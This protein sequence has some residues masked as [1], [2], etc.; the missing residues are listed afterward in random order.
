MLIEIRD[1]ASSWVAYIIIGLLVLSFALWGIQEYFGGGATVPVAEINGNEISQV[2]FNNQFQQYKQR[3][4]AILGNNYQQQYPD[5]G[6]I[7]KDVINSMVRTELLRQEVT[8]AGYRISDASLIKNIQQ[9]PQF[10]QDGKFDPALYERSLSAGRYNKAQFERE[11]REQEQ[12]RQMEASLAASSFIPKADLQRF[13]KLSEQTRDF[14]YAIVKVSSDTISVSDEES[15]NY[16]NENQQL[17]QTPEQ[18]KLAYVELKE[19]D[20][21]KEITVNAEDVRAIYDGQPERYMTD[22]LRKTRHILLK[23][24]NEAGADGL[25]W[26]E[27]LDKA[28][29]LVKQLDDGGDFAELATQHSQDSLSA[30]KGGEIGLIAAGD[31]TNKELEDTLF[32]L[33]VGEYSRPVRT[34]Q[35]IQ[36]FKLDE[37]QASEQKPFESVREKII[38]E[39]KG[40]LAQEQFIEIAEELS[41]LVF[42][43]PDEL[44]EVS[45]DYDLEI[46]QTDWLASNSNAEI[47]EFPKVKAL[48][49]SQNILKEELN[50]ELIQVAD[51]HV[52]AFR[53]LEYKESSTKPLE[54]VTDE[55]KGAIA[56]RKAA[57]QATT[58]GKKLLADLQ[59]GASLEKI[60][61]E[62]SLELKNPGALKRD[63]SSVAFTLMQHVFNLPRPDT[64]QVIKDGMEMPD[65]TYVLLELS[66]VKEDAAELDDEKAAQLSQRV[67]YG[68][69]EFNAVI[70]AIRQT[71]DVQIFEDSLSAQ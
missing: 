11:I 12:L 68:R 59:A 65:G 27:A 19:E 31:F 45:G 49:F 37:I 58:E 42:E 25:E 20:L 67:N 22:E 62:H 5:E 55:I 60:A 69:R 3:L 7:R 52:I 23:V 61:S 64:G 38:N 10:Q 66:E 46:K 39:R 32:S 40:Q 14:D 47:F 44:P 48:A 8:D 26:D 4:R 29:E 6:A 50:S 1:R 9:I 17:F 33:K 16:Y 63:D 43:Q 53:L 15:R 28:N 35:G 41:N 30:D 21:V 54:E 70:D 56:V 13:Q 18:V 51:G 36:I 57:E 24:P 71:A 34:E 2:Q